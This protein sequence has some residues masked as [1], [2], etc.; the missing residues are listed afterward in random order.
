MKRV[1]NY[2]ILVALLLGLVTCIGAKST[3]QQTLS[4]ASYAVGVAALLIRAWW[5]LFSIMKRHDN[6][7]N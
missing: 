3:E 6:R 7:E 1:L 5:A 4:M 2:I